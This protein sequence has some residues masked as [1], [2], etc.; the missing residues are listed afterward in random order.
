MIWKR[1]HLQLGSV[2]LDGVHEVSDGF[3]K[4]PL[5]IL[6]HT[7]PGEVLWLQIAGLLALSS[8][9][10]QHCPR[11]QKQMHGCCCHPVTLQTWRVQ[12]FLPH[13]SSTHHKALGNSIYP[14]AMSGS[15]S[16]YAS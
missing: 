13:T 12:Q 15:T 3:V 4:T 10:L 9:A 14:D 11:S 6:P 16:A 2:G 1:W 8:K 7:N 5:G